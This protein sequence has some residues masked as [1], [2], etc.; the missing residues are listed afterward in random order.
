MRLLKASTSPA[1]LAYL[2]PE[3]VKGDAIDART[4]I[5]ALGV[6]LYQM[7]TG[8]MPFE[9]VTSL[10]M[11]T[12]LVQASPLSPRSLRANVPAAA[13]QVILCAMAK[14]SQDRYA[15]AQHCASAFRVALT[16]AGS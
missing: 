13:E 12:Q 14:H 7:V 8:K 1:A 11:A 3:Q 16:A 2:A 9:A 6:I 15:F 4:D 5:Y 10:E